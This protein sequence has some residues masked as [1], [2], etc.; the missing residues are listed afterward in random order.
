MSRDICFFFKDIHLRKTNMLHPKIEL[1]KK[2]FLERGENLRCKILVFSLFFFVSG[3]V[4]G[5][6]G[7]K[8]TQQFL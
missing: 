7:K 3:G 8:T 4:V 2:M 5:F 6:F 1:W